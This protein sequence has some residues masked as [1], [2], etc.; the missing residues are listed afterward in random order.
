[1]KLAIIIACSLA[2]SSAAAESKV[3][4][5]FKQGKQ[6]LAEKKFAE[7][8]ATFE[9]VDKLEPGIGAKLNVARCY[10]DWEKLAVA[11]RW[12]EDAQKMAIETKDKRAAKIKELIEALDVDV[13]RLTIK[14]PPKIDPA[15]AAVQLDGKPFPVD[16]LGQEQR[17]D[18]GKHEI[19]YMA[20]KSAKTKTVKLERGAASEV[21]LPF[22]AT[23]ISKNPEPPPGKPDAGG[24]SKRKL[25]GIIAG[26]SGVALLGVS[27]VLTLTARSNY[28]DALKSECMGETDLCSPRGVKITG[29]AKSRANIATVVGGVG[30]AAVATGVILYLTAPKPSPE[31]RTVYVTPT[32]DDGGASV[33]VGGRF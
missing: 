26:G 31:K 6:Q 24:P 28:N 15:S 12:Y 13:P 11:Y 10:E 22:D 9:E 30:L 8:C 5:L 25:Y 21:E 33:I 18:P 29:N 17:V 32:V 4:A 19:D 2:A 27:G 16:K 7:A 20:G 23:A 14:L 3:D 1:M